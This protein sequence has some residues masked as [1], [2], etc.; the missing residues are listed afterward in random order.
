MDMFWNTS[1]GTKKPQSQRRR[2]CGDSRAHAPSEII[3]WGPSPT[4]EILV[5]YQIKKSFSIYVY[6]YMQHCQLFSFLTT[7][8]F[9]IYNRKKFC[10]KLTSLLG[11]TELSFFS[12]V[13]WKCRFSEKAG[14]L[15]ILYIYLY[16]AYIYI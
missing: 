5:I 8:K 1:A 9:S 2:L 16:T 13:K 3:L 14:D 12:S 10:F 7:A 6:I 11:N 4:P 15:A